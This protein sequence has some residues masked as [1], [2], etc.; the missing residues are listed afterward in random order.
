MTEDAW[1]EERHRRA[2]EDRL[3]EEARHEEAVDELRERDEAVARAREEQREACARLVAD[4][5]DGRFGE[6]DQLDQFESS[7]SVCR[8]TPLDTTPLSDELERSWTE[9]AALVDERDAAVR[10]LRRVVDHYGWWG[11]EVINAARAVL[12]KYPAAR[13]KEELTGDNRLVDPTKGIEHAHGK[14][15]A[16]PDEA[17]VV[18]RGAAERIDAEKRAEAAEFARDEATRRMIDLARENG[19]LAAALTGL[20][21]AYD[22]SPFVLSESKGASWDSRPDAREAAQ[23]WY[24]ALVTLSRRKE[25]TAG[26]DSEVQRLR[27]ELARVSEEMGLPSGVGPAPGELRRLLADDDARCG[28]DF[29]LRLLAES[30]LLVSGYMR[31]PDGKV[32]HLSELSRM[33]RALVAKEGT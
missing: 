3:A 18:C 24:V 15:I 17:C 33:A 22:V 28:L 19:D 9:K 16:A 6:D 27:S 14:H 23:A 7:E 30:E 20:L 25:G 8:A 10:A 26:D 12:A 5:A 13:L 21:K 29:T 2:E 1:H 32:M 11:T 31:T 4:W